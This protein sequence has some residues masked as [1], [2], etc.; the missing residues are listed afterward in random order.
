MAHVDRADQA[1]ALAESVGA[2]IAWDSLLLDYG[3]V[4]NGDRAWAMRDPDADWHIVLQDDAVP[5]DGFL[6]H[7]ANALAHADGM[8]SFYLGTGRPQQV[9]VGIAVAEADRRG[10]AWL[11]ST[12]LFWG[13]AVAMRTKYVD[14]FLAWGGPRVTIGTYDKRLSI[15]AH[16]SY[17]QVSYTLPCLVDHADG[18]SLVDHPWGAADMKRRAWRVGTPHRWDT[19]R[20]VIQ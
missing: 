12:N 17:Q 18:P 14:E 15:F 4:V 9:A 20:V 5:V 13:V 3:E 2:D 6:E 11:Q 7:A 1:S 16:A 19:T 8:V 10:A